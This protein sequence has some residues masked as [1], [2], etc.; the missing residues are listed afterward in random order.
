MKKNEFYAIMDRYGA[1]VPKL[2]L[3]NNKKIALALARGQKPVPYTAV[4]V[5]VLVEDED[6]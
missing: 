5:R 3:H 1:I 4:M 6:I 2:G